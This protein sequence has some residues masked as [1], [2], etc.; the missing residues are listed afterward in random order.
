MP[1][2]RQRTTVAGGKYPGPPGEAHPSRPLA[3]QAR[4]GSEGPPQGPCRFDGRACICQKHFDQWGTG[5]S[6]RLPLEFAILTAGAERGEVLG[7]RSGRRN[8]QIGKRAV[9]HNRPSG[10]KS[11]IEHPASQLSDRGDGGRPQDGGIAAFGV[12]FFPG[13]KD[14]AC[15]YVI[16]A[17]HQRSFVAPTSDV[18]GLNGFRQRI[19]G[20]GA[21]NEQRFPRDGRRRPPFAHACGGT[22][23][24]APLSA[25]AT[26]LEKRRK[27]NGTRGPKFCEPE[28]GPSNVVRGGK[29][30]GRRGGRRSRVSQNSGP[31]SQGSLSCRALPRF[32]P[33]NSSPIFS[34]S[35]SEVRSCLGAF[36]N[37]WRES[38][39]VVI[40]GPT[41]RARKREPVTPFEMLEAFAA[42][43][44]TEDSRLLC[45]NNAQR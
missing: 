36:F 3:A 12:F 31:T 4:K 15:R 18:Y 21:A 26:R 16:L 20:L 37:Q 13:Q 39:S 41:R 5:P 42:P 32:R 9:D 27:L 24:N 10:M 29:F 19:Q 28:A 23:P 35:G 30:R 44:G 14:R 25:A 1:A 33:W 7:R 43:P 45:P 38:A 6:R 2:A 8:R 34:E 22:K 40:G 17:P 11:G